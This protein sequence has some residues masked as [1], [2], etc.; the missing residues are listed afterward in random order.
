MPQLLIAAGRP[1]DPVTLALEPS[2]APAPN[3]DH[4]PTRA[5]EFSRAVDA[6][7]ATAL[8]IPAGRAVR[9]YV[10]GNASEPAYGV[11]SGFLAVVGLE[12]LL[13]EV[14]YQ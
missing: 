1:G 5:P 14:V 3:F 10:P 2:T 9:F 6:P 13:V 7:N 11:D 8:R 12:A 4:R